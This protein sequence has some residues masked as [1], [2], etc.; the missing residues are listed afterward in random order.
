MYILVLLMLAV[1]SS[2]TKETTYTFTDVADYSVISDNLLGRTV[3][4]IEYNNEGS[5]ITENTIESPNTG[6]SYTFIADERTDKVKVN[7]TLKVQAGPNIIE[8]NR[9]VQTVYYLEKGKDISIEL[10]DHSI[11]GADEPQ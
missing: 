7:Y 1:F 8:H 4:L 10:N 9:W 11:V 5:Y 6:Q 3:Y 2:C